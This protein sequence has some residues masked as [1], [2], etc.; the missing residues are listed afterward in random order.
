MNKS[1]NR[2]NHAW[3]VAVAIVLA[4]VGLSSPVL[5]KTGSS[6]TDYT[7]AD[8]SVVE[9]SNPWKVDD[10]TSGYSQD[11]AGD[12]VTLLNG[13]TRFI[14]TTYPG[15]VTP[16]A[17][18]DALVAQY[19]QTRDK[20]V[21][22]DAGESGSTAF[23]SQVFTDKSG[24][25]WGSYSAWSRSADERTLIGTEVL[26]PIDDLQSALG[27]AQSAVAID[28]V[29]VLADVDPAAVSDAMTHAEATG[30]RATPATKTT[31]S[32]GS[33][34]D[35]D[36]AFI[37]AGLLTGESYESPQF[38]YAVAWNSPWILNPDD[39]EAVISNTSTAT[40]ALSIAVDGAS[41]SLLAIAGLESSGSRPAD[42][43]A[44]WASQDFLDQYA[45]AGTTVLLEDSAITGG[46]VVTTGPLQSDAAST[47]V[48]VREVVSR[49]GG[50]TIVFLTLIVPV[51]QFATDYESVQ[52]KV[53]LDGN[54]AMGFFSTSEIV[55]V[56]P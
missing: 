22:V 53:T 20:V 4:T 9:W 23:G 16:T 29:A 5:A 50:R 24:A 44:T 37:E 6:G 2:W 39:N 26:S 1:M 3:S 45:G 41:Y 12:V 51:D 8:R 34:K 46:A 18:R 10:R 47:V 55:D 48:T 35:L 43:T 27:D 38:G 7:L 13:D 15:I 30:T 14:L 33:A 49:D 28:G 42:L 31:T 21:V 52:E 19:E 36:P 40:D 25:I 11:S 32:G 17:G 54:P 56:L